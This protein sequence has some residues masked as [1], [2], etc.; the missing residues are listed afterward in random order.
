MLFGRKP[1]TTLPGSRRTLKSKRPDN[2][3]DH[4]ADQRR[5]E[6]QAV[7]YDRMAGIGKRPLSNREPVFVWNTLKNIWQP[8]TV[9]NRAQPMGR[10][11]TYAVDI[12]RTIYQRAREHLRP[13]SQSEVHVLP[14]AGSNLPLTVIPVHSS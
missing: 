7:F 13:R 10:P 5:Q 8:G 3:L 1:Q 11:R 12:Q 4:K 6:R 14:S 2:D 9:L